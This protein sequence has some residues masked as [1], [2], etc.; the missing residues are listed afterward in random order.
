M[1]KRGDC[2]FVVERAG[3]LVHDL[4]AANG[5]RMVTIGPIDFDGYG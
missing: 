4:P 2:L 5:V 3:P 1:L